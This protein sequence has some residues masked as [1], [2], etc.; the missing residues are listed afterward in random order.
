MFIAQTGAS[1]TEQQ[2]IEQCQTGQSDWQ[3][4][5]AQWLRGSSGWLHRH[6]TARLGCA[7]TADDAVQE[8]SLKVMSAI[9]QFEGRSTLRTWVTRIADNHCNGVIRQ[10]CAALISDHL[11]YSMILMEQ[12]RFAS[13]EDRDRRADVAHKIGETLQCLTQSNQEILHLRF[14]SDQSL[15]EIARSL[16]LSLSATKMRLYRALAVFKSIY[17]KDAVS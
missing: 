2:L 3:A 12:N 14:Y 16:S 15:D 5:L 4:A 8:I 9:G 11:Q 1:I 10:Q 7:M 6:C 17:P 13:R